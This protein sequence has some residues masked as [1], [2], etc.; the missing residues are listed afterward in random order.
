MDAVILM[1]EKRKKKHLR[2][3]YTTTLSF[4]ASLPDDVQG[5]YA[6]SLCAVKYSMDP[7]VDLKE[8]I[9]EMVKNVG[10]RNWEDMEELI[11]CYVVLN[12]TEIHGFIVQAFLSLCS[13]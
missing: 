4:S 2:H 8:S 6:D 11:Y 9:I 5:I 12:S 1:N 10:V 13:S 3:N 7:L